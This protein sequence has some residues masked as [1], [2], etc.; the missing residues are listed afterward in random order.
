MLTMPDRYDCKTLHFGDLIECIEM[1]SD[2]HIRVHLAILSRRFPRQQSEHS[3]S[4][5]LGTGYWVGAPT[6]G[7]PLR[8]P[9]TEAWENRL[10]RRPP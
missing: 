10:A 4:S 3:A 2:D 6:H 1:L 7:S 5:F 8:G 9:M